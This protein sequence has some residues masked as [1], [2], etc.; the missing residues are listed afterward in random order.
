MVKK[1]G[2]QG[3]K[4]PQEER[5]AKHL[6]KISHRPIMAQSNSSYCSASCPHRKSAALLLPQVCVP[7]LTWGKRLPQDGSV[8]RNS[9]M[10]AKHKGFN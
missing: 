6:L 9:E 3:K 2:A 5:K 4:R 7:P 10:A 1:V 8:E